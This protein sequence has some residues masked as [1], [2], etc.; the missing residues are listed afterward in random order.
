MLRALLAA[1]ALA[2]PAA[3][4]DT[5]ELRLFTVGSGEVG[6]GYYAAAAAI[7]GQMNRAE[8]GR[9]RCSPEATAGSR[10]NL[11]ALHTGQLDFA[12][13]QSDW[14]RAAYEGAGAFAETGPM[15]DLR[16]VMAL[17]PEAITV[18]A[19]RDA[20]IGRLAELKGKRVDIG[21][22]ASGRHATVTRM[23]EA[24]GAGP[25]DFAALLELPAGAAVSELCAGRIDAT[26]LILGHPNP[27]TARALAEC[28]A[29]LVPVDG[30]AIA[31]ALAGP[32]YTRTA[33]PAMTYPDL[34][35]D[36]PSYAVTATL[37]TRAG[38]PADAVSA[39]VADTLDG[40][41]ELAITAPILA[42]LDPAAMRTRGLT[43]PLHDG[44]SAA[45]GAD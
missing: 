39:L 8:R 41:P 43:A 4:Q 27:T 17:Y 20:G 33:I 32:D 36:V 35:G 5:P 34:R 6:G 25:A 22:P 44:A 37:V 31:E 30:P 21:Q 11:M 7:C 9:L 12:L 1:F 24:L 16:S 40:L 18:L 2:A 15:T 14:Q 45:F 3:A 38:T 19:R 23:I 29:V 28:G 13:V 10:Y 42:R 26:I